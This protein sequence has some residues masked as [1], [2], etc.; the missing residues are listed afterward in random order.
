MARMDCVSCILLA[1]GF[2]TTLALDGQTLEGIGGRELLIRRQ[3]DE[4]R[5]T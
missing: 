5:K 2:E 1:S 3:N 4:A